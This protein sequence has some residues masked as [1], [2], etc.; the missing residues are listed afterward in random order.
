V[1]T[2][3]PQRHR[4]PKLHHRRQSWRQHWR[5]CRERPI[6]RR[7]SVDFL[8]EPLRH[9][10]PATTHQPRSLM[11]AATQ[12]ETK[13]TSRPRQTLH[14]GG[15]PKGSH[16]SPERATRPPLPLKKR[17]NKANPR[18]RKKQASRSNLQ[19]YMSTHRG[20]GL[21]SLHRHPEGRQRRGG[22]RIDGRSKIALRVA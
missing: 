3:R 12:G 13:R 6:E 9:T 4:R 10:V 8:T 21:P 20:A 15:G 5:N 17:T 2:K 19:L 22:Q 14:R 1:K 7:S 11:G 18:Q 16:E